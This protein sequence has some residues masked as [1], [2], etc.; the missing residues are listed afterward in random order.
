MSQGEVIARSSRAQRVAERRRLERREVVVAAGQWLVVSVGI[1]AG[2]SG[3]L[4]VG[5]WALGVWP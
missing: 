1:V 5:L 2:M 4:V 3:L